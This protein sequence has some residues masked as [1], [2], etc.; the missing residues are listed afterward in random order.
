MVVIVVYIESH[1]TDMD[2]EL[3]LT[4]FEEIFIRGTSQVRP[5]LLIMDG[6]GPHISYNIIKRVVGENIKIIL[7][8]PHTIT[9]LQLLDVGLFRSL[10]AN[11]SKVT[12]GVK[13]LNVTGN[14]QDINKT[15]FTAVFKES[16][17]DR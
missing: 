10:K 6:H 4:W 16:L 15:N 8:P 11:L 3:F 12:A 1:L 14:Y 2:E 13:M 17:K 5:T 7:L 9:V